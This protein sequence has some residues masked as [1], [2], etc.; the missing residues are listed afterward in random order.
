VAR[1]KK[2]SKKSS[3]ASRFRAFTDEHRLRIIELLFAGAKN[4]SQLAQELQLTQSLT[5]HHI[6][7]LKKD[8]IVESTKIGRVHEYRLAAGV[9]RKSSE[10][11]LD[12]GCCTVHLK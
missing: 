2:A 7:A 4:V 10:N 6:L 5:S 8:G 11:I 9:A 1:T 3:R 12:L